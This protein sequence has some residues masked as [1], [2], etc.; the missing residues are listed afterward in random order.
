MADMGCLRGIVVER[1][2]LTMCTKFSI[3]QTYGL[4]SLT[5]CYSATVW[6]TMSVAGLKFRHRSPSAKLSRSG[7]FGT[8]CWLCGVVSQ[9]VTQSEGCKTWTF[10]SWM[11]AHSREDKSYCSLQQSEACFHSMW[12]NVEWIHRSNR[13]TARVYQNQGTIIIF[14]VHGGT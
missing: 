12:H 9:L 10:T 7:N 6:P 4:K 11:N 2:P 14:I 3:H 1:A 13:V 5:F 8:K